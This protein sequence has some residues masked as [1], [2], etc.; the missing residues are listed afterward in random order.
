MKRRGPE[1]LLLVLLTVVVCR[2]VARG[3]VVFINEIHYDNTGA[4][5]GEAV[6]IAGQAGLNLSAY[7]LI[8]YN[9]GYKTVR[10]EF[11]IEAGTRINVRQRLQSG[12]SKLS[13]LESRH[14]PGVVPDARSQYTGQFSRHP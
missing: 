3:Q 14:G 5:A 8:F 2:G 12:E 7:E 9:E 13:L 1:L 4:D 11:T 10:K 6:E